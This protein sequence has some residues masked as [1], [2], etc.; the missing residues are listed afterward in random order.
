MLGG[1]L[2]PEL[3]NLDDCEIEKIVKEGFAKTLGIKV[4]PEMVRIYRHDYAIP[5]YQVRHREI[6]QKIADLERQLPGIFFTG[7]AF[8]GVGINDCI[9]ASY[10]ICEKVIEYCK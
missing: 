9:A 8:D 3:I 7:N 10:K 4:N 6:V 5:Q 1:A 2:R